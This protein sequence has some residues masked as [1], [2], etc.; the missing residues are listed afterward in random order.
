MAFGRDLH[1]G[2]RLLARNPAFAVTAIAVMS[3]GIGAATAVFSVVR[4]VLLEQLPY[5]DP[6]RLVLFRVDAPG[7]VRDPSL[8]GEEFA[9]LRDRTDL[10][11]SVG[12]VYDSEGNLTKPDD[13]EAVTAASVSPAF[14]Q[15][16]GVAPILG[17]TPADVDVGKQWVRGVNVSYG[18][19][20]RKFDGDPRV[21]GRSI[22]INN[23]PMTVVGVLP[24][25]FDLY[26]GYGVPVPTR[27]DVWFPQGAIAD[28]M[29]TYRDYVRVIAAADDYA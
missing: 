29:Q 11:E 9:A 25:G 26:L 13:M 8:T 3:L 10:F 6:S 2:L 28:G 24:R 27:V 14:F 1:F 23:I 5:R 18:L 12:S 20:Q 15:T 16:L 22:D 19:W 4:G 21:V 7:Y 17:R